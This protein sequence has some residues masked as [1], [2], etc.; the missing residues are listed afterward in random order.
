MVSKN[1]TF[2][3]GEWVVS[4][5]L[6]S[7][8]FSFFLKGLLYIVLEELAYEKVSGILNQEPKKFSE[9]L[10]F[11]VFSDWLSGILEPIHE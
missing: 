11:S 4:R 5:L 1:I 6:L 8:S 10:K 7:Q 2:S 9:E 3:G